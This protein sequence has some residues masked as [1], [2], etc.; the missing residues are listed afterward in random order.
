MPAK[1]CTAKWCYAQTDAN[2][3][4][5]PRDSLRSSCLSCAAGHSARISI[6][7]VRPGSKGGLFVW[8]RLRPS[9]E[10]EDL[11]VSSPCSLTSCA[12]SPLKTRLSRV[13]YN[14]PHDGTEWLSA[15]QGAALSRASSSRY[16]CFPRAEY[17]LRAVACM[18]SRGG[19]RPVSGISLAVE[20]Q[21][22]PPVID[23]G[24][25]GFS[26]GGF[27]PFAAGRAVVMS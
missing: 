15:P 1:Q 26:G 5:R 2:S 7:G 10:A 4:F 11:P 16:P 22:S 27:G 14:Y 13:S 19:G 25:A 6:P 17:A 18:G 12:I 23:S 21:S 8:L 24:F 20:T 3:Q 9:A